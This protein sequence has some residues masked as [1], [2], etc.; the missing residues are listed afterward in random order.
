MSNPILDEINEAYVCKDECC[1]NAKLARE[2]GMRHLAAECDCG[3]CNDALGRSHCGDDA[4][5]D[6]LTLSQDAGLKEGDLITI[7]KPL[8]WWVRQLLRLLKWLEYDAS[9]EGR[10]QLFAV[11][12]VVSSNSFEV[13]Q[14]E[15][16]KP[17]DVR[18]F[19]AKAHGSQYDTILRFVQPHGAM[20][21]VYTV[22]DGVV[23]NW[24]WTEGR[25]WRTFAKAE[26]FVRDLGYTLTPWPS[27]KPAVDD[28]TPV[29]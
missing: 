16:A 26:E 20:V 23:M 17:D 18:M 24:K 8:P 6:A 10:K 11:G 29:G 12:G 27:I 28:G 19:W 14:S 4:K 15:E 7:R 9:I 21:R 13:E 3:E 5:P 1:G 2:R 22:F 25:Q